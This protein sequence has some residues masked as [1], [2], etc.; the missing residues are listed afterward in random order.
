MGELVRIDLDE[1]RRQK[2]RSDDR[3]LVI[4]PKE[5]LKTLSSTGLVDHRLFKEDGNRLHAK[6]EKFTSLWYV[7]YE[8]GQVPPAL[9]Q[10]WTSFNKLMTFT[11]DY[12][13]NRN[14]DIIEVQD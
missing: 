6:L 11:K 9:Q 3:I 4:R 1:R 5:G 8:N 7:D 14:I 2:M 12:F 10:R 13:N